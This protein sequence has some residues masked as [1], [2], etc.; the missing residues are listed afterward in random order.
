[1]IR[2]LT[3]EEL[4]F[5]PKLKRTMH[6]DRAL[7]FSER[8]GWDVNL[9][10]NGEEHDEYDELN[11]LYVIL[12]NDIGEHEGS[13]RFLPTVGRVMVNDHFLHVIGGVGICSPFIWECTRF[14]LSR[15]AKRNTAAK[16][17]CAGAYMMKESCIDHF[18]GV[19]DERMERVYRTI[20]ATPDLLGKHTTQY[21]TIG[22]GL[23][24]FDQENFFALCRKARITPEQLDWYFD[25][26]EIPTWMEQ[27]TQDLNIPPIF[28]NQAV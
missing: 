28:L 1:M 17:M 21:G 4:F 16:L 27:A 8:L 5:F 3:G 7:Q 11:P 13:M 15:T 20:G 10:V 2:I 24:E 6:L 19:F 12:E 23:W 26:W 9:D 18:V 14:C 25:A 22:V